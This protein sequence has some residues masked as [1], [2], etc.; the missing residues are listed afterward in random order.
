MFLNP[1]N[2]NPD[3]IIEIGNVSTHA[4]ARFRTVAHCSPE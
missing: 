3:S 2:K 1:Q 4:I